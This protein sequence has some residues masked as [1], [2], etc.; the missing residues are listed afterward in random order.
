MP[1]NFVNTAAIAKL[2]HRLNT[3][4]TAM[5]RAS[6]LST[7][8]GVHEEDGNKAYAPGK[9]I[10]ISQIAAVHELGTTRIPRRSWLLDYISENRATIDEAERRVVKAI[11]LGRMTADV[12]YLQL[13]A[14]IVSKIKQRIRDRIEPGLADS[15]IA[16][17]SVGGKLSDIPLIDEGRFLSSIRAKLERVA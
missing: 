14:F 16:A 7:T 4:A 6:K 1:R 15:T 3:A 5:A 12:A 2:T 17:K 9:P 8:V 11:A 10:T 13:G